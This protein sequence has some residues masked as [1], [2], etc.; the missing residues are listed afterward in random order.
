MYVADWGNSR[1]QKFSLDGRYLAT[2]GAPGSGEGALHRPSGVAVDKDG[3]VYVTDW[4]V[5]RLVLYDADGNYLTSFEG[6]EVE[7]S[8]WRQETM[9]QADVINARKRVE[10]LSI[11]RKFRW[12][13]AVKVDVEGRFMVLETQSAR[14]QIYVKEQHWVEPAFNL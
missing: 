9:I 12:P 13:V 6:D 11:E 4:D 10:D 1:V 2:F 7:P 5:H 8:P 3:Y 14:I